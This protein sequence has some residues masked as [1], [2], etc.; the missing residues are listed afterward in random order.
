MLDLGGREWITVGGVCASAPPYYGLAGERGGSR[1]LK[2]I[3]QAK[4][5]CSSPKEKYPN[6]PPNISFVASS[7][8][9]CGVSMMVSIDNRYIEH[10][11]VLFTLPV[12]E[13]MVEARF[14]MN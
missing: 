2:Y 7:S 6:A 10:T 11:C 9:A 14:W 5:D 3:P 1:V 12:C 13:D 4:A 8:T